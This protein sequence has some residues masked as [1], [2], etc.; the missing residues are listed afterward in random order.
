MLNREVVRYISEN[1]IINIDEF[2][3]DCFINVVKT[4]MFFKIIGMYFCDGSV[5]FRL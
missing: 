3:R 1:L 4:S 5:K 2:G